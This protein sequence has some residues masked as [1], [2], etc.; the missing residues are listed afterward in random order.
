MKLMVLAFCVCVEIFFLLQIQSHLFVIILFKYLFLLESVSGVCVF[1]G[2][3]HTC[4]N[5][6]DLT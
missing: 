1:L 4:I 3:M 6:M 2:V 5:R